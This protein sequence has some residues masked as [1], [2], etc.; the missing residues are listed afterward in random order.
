VHCLK[1]LPPI[2]ENCQWAHFL[3]GHDE[4][5]L[6]RLYE[7]DRQEVFAAFGPDPGMQLYGRGIRR[8]LAPMFDGDLRRVEMAHSLIFSLPGAQ[9][10]RY[11]DEIGMGDDLSLEE[12]NSVRTPMQWTPGE[13]GGFSTARRADLIRPVIQS[14]RYRPERV[15]VLDQLGDP[16]SLLSRMQR[17]IALRRGCPEV[18]FGETVLVETDHPAVFAHLC[19]WKGHA[20][21]ALHNLAEGACTA[22]IDEGV[23]K[24]R[25]L[26]ALAGDEVYPA[27]G[28]DFALNGFG[29]RW[30]RLA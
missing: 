15:N 14:E 8:R 2:P 13:S 6:G 10:I 17:L 30:M 20:V 16:N 27:T 18:G 29:Y 1:R 19:R 21:L 5:D 12:R 4:L 25:R 22:R 28:Q 23:L 11:G 9:V 24:G 26:V 7:Q 3:R